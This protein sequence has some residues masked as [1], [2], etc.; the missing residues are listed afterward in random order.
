M[1]DFPQ[2]EV[3]C[4]VSDSSPN[5]RA[6]ILTVV[7]LIPRGRVATYGDVARMAGFPGQARQVGYALAAMGGGSD[8]P[9]HRVINAR[10]EIS[11]R[12]NSEGHIE[13][14][15]LLEREAIEF[16]RDGRVSLARFGWQGDDYSGNEKT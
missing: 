10:G 15:R 2:V 6:Q 12:A 9:W 7:A 11:Q 14:R 13:Q 4:N 5:K 1:P 16:D 3:R 8:V